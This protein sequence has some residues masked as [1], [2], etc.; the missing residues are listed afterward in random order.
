[1]VQANILNNAWIG[2]GPGI[3]RNLGIAFWLF[4]QSLGAYSLDL[5]FLLSGDLFGKDVRAPGYHV[6]LSFDYLD[7]Q[8]YALA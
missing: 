6:G 2:A 7:S 8:F 5:V 3:S 4:T 1:M